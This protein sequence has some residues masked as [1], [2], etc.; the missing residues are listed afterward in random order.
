MT[1]QMTN[2]EPVTT[3]P[4]RSE[5][6]TSAQ[7]HDGT[8]EPTTG[9]IANAVADAAA[10]AP[11]ATPREPD[12]ATTTPPNPP[13]SGRVSRVASLAAA[14]DEAAQ[15]RALTARPEVVALH[16][17]RVRTQ[18]DALLWAGVG[19]GLLFTTVNVHQ[20]A[21]AGAAV[22]SAGW[23]VA[24]LLDPMVS[25]LLLAV[26]R[27]EQITARYRVKLDAWPGRAKWCAFMVTY[28]MNTWTSWGLSGGAFSVSAVVLHSVPPLLVVVSA[29]TAPALRKQLT[30]AAQRALEGAAHEPDP[31]RPHEDAPRAVHDAATRGAHGDGPQRLG[32]PGAFAGER[33]VRERLVHEPSA[34]QP[35]AVAAPATRQRRV[36]PRRARPVPRRLLSDYLAQAR[37]ALT[38]AASSGQQPDPTPAWC[39]RTT[40]C[41]AGTSV[42]LA[43]ALRRTADEPT[44]GRTASRHAPGVDP[45]PEVDAAVD[46]DQARID[47]SAP[48]VAA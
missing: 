43:A 41:S 35:Q 45:A 15:V 20:F 19:L 10:A 27:A 28:L 33:D 39:R 30:E 22:F 18:V 26:L 13:G 34:E 12:P 36:S 40:G 23:W 14:A 11:R 37:S 7:S 8:R 47:H 9:M 44:E 48:D 38:E 1:A 5:P 17:D 6:T 21:A 16:I 3:T 32:E 31:P 42:K 46:L 29:E 2:N 25:L 4:T 24:W